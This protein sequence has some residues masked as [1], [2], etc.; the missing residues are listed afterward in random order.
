[1]IPTIITQALKADVI[2]L[3]SLAPKRDFTFVG[4][5]VRGFIQAAESGDLIGAEVNLGSGRAL[6]I[7]ELVQTVL[8]QLGRQLPIV[9][10]PQRIRPEGSEVMELVASSDKAARLMDW[11]PLI[12]LA[13]GLALTIAWLR[14]HIDSYRHDEYSV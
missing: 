4:D 7:G 8:A 12:S 11:H 9:V 3:G 14:E 2:K 1:V 5:T 6:S 10:D 13:E